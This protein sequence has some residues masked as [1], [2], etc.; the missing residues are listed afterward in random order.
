MDFCWNYFP[1][2]L[3]LLRCS[4]A[5]I[6]FVMFVGTIYHYDKTFAAHLALVWSKFVLFFFVWYGCC[7]T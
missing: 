6:S 3:Y 2:R 5:V 7:N 1:P 4:A